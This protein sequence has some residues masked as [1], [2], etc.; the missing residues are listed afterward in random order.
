MNTI[1]KRLTYANVMSSIAV[2]VV[3]GGAAFAATQL[4]K[5]SVG[6]KQLK[7]NAVVSSKVKNGSL[8]AADFGAGQLPAGP[9]GAQGPQGPAGPAG[10]AVAYAH[11]EEDG[12]VDLENSKNIAQVNVESPSA[13]VYCF[14]NLSFTVHVVVA[15]P[16]AFG[17]E[18]GIIVN[19][20]FSASGLAGC[21][22]ENDFR[23][24]TTTAA[25]PETAS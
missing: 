19:P 22:G 13:G 8:K 3:L 23:V 5:N 17:P 21:P 7:K 18:D 1:R 4:P 12:T 14:R 11:I 9:Q 25:A 16:D 15:S 20:T 2:F 24:R 6:T 10:S